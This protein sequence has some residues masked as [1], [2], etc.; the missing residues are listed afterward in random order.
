MTEGNDEMGTNK[1]AWA[2]DHEA[3]REHG[4]VMLNTVMHRATDRNWML[5]SVRSAARSRSAQDD[6]ACR[7]WNA[8]RH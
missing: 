5:M 8:H 6:K 1:L 7:V 3:L 4:I 2:C